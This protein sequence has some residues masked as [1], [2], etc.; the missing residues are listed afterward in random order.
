VERTLA[1]I[2]LVV[3]LSPALARADGPCA[4]RR[5][6][7]WVVHQRLLGVIEPLG[8]Q[9][10]LALG[11]CWPL[12][13]ERADDVAIEAA[14][15]E[16]GAMSYLSPVYAYGGGFVEIAPVSFL[17]LRLDVLGVGVWPLP[18]EGAGYFA[19][20]SPDAPRQ[21]SDLPPEL[22]T[23]AAGW[24]VRGTAT[25]SGGIPLGGDWAIVMFDSLY[26]ERLSIGHGAYFLSVQHDVVQ[27]NE[28]SVI[29]NEALVALDVEISGGP[30]LRMGAYSATRVVASTGYVGH[31][32]GGVVTLEWD[33]PIPEIAVLEVFVRGGGYTHHAYRVGPALLGYVQ[34]TWDAGPI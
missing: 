33:R 18:L 31:H 14:H 29:G 8:A 17:A 9:H 12:F 1:A 16:V 20:P 11:A 19:L 27:G 23:T 4:G 3:A 22:A 34:I 10:D 5:S 24:S 30:Q 7:R 2:G 28:D 32:L 15:V 13:P 6:P 21:G 26:V 25:L